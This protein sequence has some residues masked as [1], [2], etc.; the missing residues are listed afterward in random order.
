MR[1]FRLPLLRGQNSGIIWIIVE[2]GGLKEYFAAI[3][4]IFLSKLFS[5]ELFL[6]IRASYYDVTWKIFCSDRIMLNKFA[7]RPGIMTVS[8]NI[9]QCIFLSCF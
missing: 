9:T 7:Y 3:F 2:I 8:D 1:L 5:V 6:S 4:A